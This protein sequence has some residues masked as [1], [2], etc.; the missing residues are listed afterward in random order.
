MKIVNAAT[1]TQSTAE[2]FITCDGDIVD[3]EAECFGDCVGK[4]VVDSFFV[5]S[6]DDM[7]KA[8]RTKYFNNTKGSF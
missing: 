6:L 5:G 4:V 3:T 8:A 2:F 7:R 1:Q